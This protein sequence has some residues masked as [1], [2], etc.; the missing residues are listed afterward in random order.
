[1]RDSAQLFGGLDTSSIK[2]GLGSGKLMALGD[3]GRRPVQNE[4]TVSLGTVRHRAKIQEAGRLFSGGILGHFFFLRRLFLFRLLTR[5]G[6]VMER[7]V[8]MF[9]SCC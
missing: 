7:M 9:D 8:E 1:L 4:F 6:V 3:D 5:G 2:H